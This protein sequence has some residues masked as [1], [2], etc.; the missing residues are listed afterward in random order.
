MRD[1][2]AIRNIRVEDYPTRGSFQERIEFLLQFG[3]LAPSTHNTQPWLFKVENNICKLHYDKARILPAADP[4][5]RDLH[6]SL[7]CC[8]ENIL[9]AAWVFKLSADVQYFDSKS[10]TLRAMLTFRDDPVKNINEKYLSTMQS[11]VNVRGFFDDLP[12]DTD[13][14][15]GIELLEDN[16]ELKIII[17]KKVIQEISS[18]SLD[19]ITKAYGNDEFRNEIGTW[20]R[21]NFSGA[22]DGM[23]GHSL[24]MSTL[25]SVVFPFMVK[26]VNLKNKVIEINKKQWETVPGVCVLS[27][28]ENIISWMKVGRLAERCMLLLENKG[29]R[30]SI[31]QAAIEFDYLQEGL[32]KLLKM[33]HLPQIL[34]RVGYMTSIQNTFSRR[35]LVKERM[36]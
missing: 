2:Q 6:I 8:I 32:K 31:F 28:E 14:L 24:R 16:I 25:V 18:L 34:F 9:T 4:K 27:G 10:D 22:N 3:I 13:I 33:K 23:V 21:N 17:N 30:S 11:R 7:G 12:I 5:Q 1:S 36:L 19:G 20:V 26:R 29:I 35:L 15:D